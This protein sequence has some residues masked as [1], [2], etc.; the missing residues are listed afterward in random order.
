MKKQMMS[1]GNTCKDVQKHYSGSRNLCRVFIFILIQAV[2]SRFIMIR[3]TQDRF[4]TTIGR[5][6]SSG[7]SWNGNDGALP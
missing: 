3:H 4:G 1:D 2:G 7:R 6:W 5:L